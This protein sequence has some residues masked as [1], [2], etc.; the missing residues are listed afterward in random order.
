MTRQNKQAPQE[1]Q[2]VYGQGTARIIQELEQG[3]VPWVQ[4]WGNPD[5]AAGIGLPAN[6]DT[7]KN[8]SGI[9][10]LLLWGAVFDRG[11][12][13]QSWLTYKQAE[14]LGGHVRKGEK[15]TTIVYADSFITRE[16]RR[17]ARNEHRDPQRIPFLK[18]YSV[19]NIEQ[20]EGLPE[21]LY[22]PPRTVLAD[23]ILLHSIQRILSALPSRYS[24]GYQM[25]TGSTPPLETFRTGSRRMARSGRRDKRN[26]GVPRAIPV[27]TSVFAPTWRVPCGL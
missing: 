3:R 7:G 20:C 23:A 16:E 4:P 10:I 25:P 15:S 13:L 19:F 14:T 27:C 8:Y 2:T 17:T 5:G 11:F 9:N 22:E 12:Q 6:A 18:R 26:V 21:N 24:P 1:R